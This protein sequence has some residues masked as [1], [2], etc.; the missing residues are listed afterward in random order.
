MDLPGLHIDW[1][2]EDDLPAIVALSQEAFPRDGWSPASLAEE[3]ALD[4]SHS[5]VARG[6][7]LLG[8]L[9]FWRILDEVQILQ[10][11][12][13]QR[14]RRMGVGRALVRRCMDE[15]HRAGG[16]TFLLE[17][18]ASNEGAL[19]LYSGLGFEQLALRRR[20]Y[21]DPVEDAVIMVSY[22]GDEEDDPG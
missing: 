13:A 10:V 2:S 17:V 16:R 6:D 7:G 3:L 8:Y 21:H 20:Y 4:C 15:A 22:S 5:L 12:T 14:A 19:K 9:I 1:A 11:A 18:R